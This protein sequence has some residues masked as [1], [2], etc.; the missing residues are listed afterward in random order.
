M[1]N[2]VRGFRRFLSLVFL[3][4]GGPM[5]G[6]ALMPFQPTDGNVRWLNDVH[7]STS[8][9]SASISM[10]TGDFS[11][12]LPCGETLNGVRPDISVDASST[13][14]MDF[15]VMGRG[16]RFRWGASVL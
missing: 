9:V 11:G 5:S 4:G 8:S 3:W 1:V 14:G 10:A 2:A 7:Q 16:K 12:L 15:K 6:F 13:W